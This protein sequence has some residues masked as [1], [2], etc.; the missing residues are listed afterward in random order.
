MNTFVHWE[1][2][3]K[4]YRILLFGNRLSAN[5]ARIR[6]REIESEVGSAIEK[7]SEREIELLLFSSIRI[8]VLFYFMII[9]L[10]IQQKTT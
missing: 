9:S 2:E 7:S 1:L 3:K 8:W 10:L 4:K 6:K 5:K